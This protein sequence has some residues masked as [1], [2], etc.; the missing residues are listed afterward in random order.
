MTTKTGSDSNRPARDRRP[1][2]PDLHT[3]LEEVLSSVWA[4]EANW[5]FD[6]RIDLSLGKRR[7]PR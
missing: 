1:E 6:D 5:R 2:V 4:A 3:Q 7:R